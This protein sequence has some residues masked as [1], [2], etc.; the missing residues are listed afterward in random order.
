MR[1]PKIWCL[2]FSSIMLASGGAFSQVPSTTFPNKPIVVIQPSTPGGS[3]DVYYRHYT[4]AITTNTGWKFIMDFKPGAGGTIGC[5]YV[6]KSAPDGHTLLLIASTLTSTPIMQPNLPY[7][8]VKSFA[9]I[10]LLGNQTNALLVS[11]KFPAKTL[12]EYVAYAKASPGKLNYA[13]NG[14]GGYAYLVGAALHHMMGIQVTDVQYKGGGQIAVALA[15]GEVDATITGVAGYLP[16]VKSGNLRLIGLA[17][18]KRAPNLPDLPTLSEQGAKGFDYAGWY[19]ILAP[20]R[21]PIST[22]RA[23]N[24]EFVKATKDPDL[25]ANLSP[26]T[27]VTSSTPEE[28]SEL[29]VRQIDR[30]HQLAKEA[31]LK[32]TE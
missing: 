30:W 25:L 22:V 27:M 18:I 28:F 32:L 15:A 23:L 3:G 17:G 20:A 21:T 5:A 16:L 24:A 26:V 10:S 12:Q 14:V 7:D 31:N 2:L 4:Q 29:I 19:G 9:P 1:K 11:A 8:T 6:A 13:N